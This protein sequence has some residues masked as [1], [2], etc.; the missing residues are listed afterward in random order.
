[1]KYALNITLTNYTILVEHWF[2]IQG[3]V[4]T[5]ATLRTPLASVTFI[6]KEIR[7]FFQILHVCSEEK[8]FRSTFDVW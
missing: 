7:D 2:L 3:G 1:M 6:M 4:F 5:I 8:N